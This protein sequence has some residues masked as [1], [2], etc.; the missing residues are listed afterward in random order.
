MQAQG[1]GEMKDSASVRAPGQS[2]LTFYHILGQLQGEL[3]RSQET[4]TDLHNL[5]VR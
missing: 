2:G 5:L 3:Q 4:G 1:L